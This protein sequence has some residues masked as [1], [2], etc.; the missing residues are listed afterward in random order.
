MRIPMN[1]QVWA[2]E[3][4]LSY[5]AS[6]HNAIQRAHLFTT[7]NEHVE[8]RHKKTGEVYWRFERGVVYVEKDGALAPIQRWEPDD[9]LPA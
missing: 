2:G 8:V 4:L 5:G 9:K 6:K 1:Y 3:R 7:L